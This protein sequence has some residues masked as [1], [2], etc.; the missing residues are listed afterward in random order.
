MEINNKA[1]YINIYFTWKPNKGEKK[2]FLIL[3]KN[4][5]LY[6]FQPMRDT[7]HCSKYPLTPF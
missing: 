4:Y 1:Q 7:N 6:R 2:V 5:I 3:N